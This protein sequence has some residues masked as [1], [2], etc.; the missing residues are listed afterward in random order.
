VSKLLENINILHAKD[1][2]EAYNKFLD[3]NYKKMYKDLE[4]SLIITDKNMPVMNGYEMCLKI[5]NFIQEN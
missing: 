5:K 4:I 2:L 3:F 1:G